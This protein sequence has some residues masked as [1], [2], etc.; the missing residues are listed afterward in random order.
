MKEMANKLVP[1]TNVVALFLVL[2]K[3]A[4]LVTI[5]GEGCQA[6]CLNA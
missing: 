5:S 2:I 3:S 6:L 4:N 1:R